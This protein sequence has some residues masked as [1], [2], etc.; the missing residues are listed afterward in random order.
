MAQ[1]GQKTITFDLIANTAQVEQSLNGIS[2]HINKIQGK[3]GTFH[4]TADVD[5]K[6][7]SKLQT[8]IKDKTIKVSVNTSDVEKLQD[9]LQA[10]SDLPDLNKAI[11]KQIKNIRKLNLDKAYSNVD[12]Q[13]ESQIVKKME[14]AQK[15]M[16]MTLKRAG[17]FESS[18]TGNQEGMMKRA[19]GFFEQIVELNG[20]LKKPFDSLNVDGTAMKLA[21]VEEQ[22]K[23]FDLPPTNVSSS[24]KEMTKEMDAQ[25]S[26]LKNLRS[27]L[28]ALHSLSLEDI[29][30]KDNFNIDKYLRELDKIDRDNYKEQL[31]KE[32]ELEESK[33][34]TGQDT[35]KDAEETKSKTKSRISTSELVKQA[36]EEA[37]IKA[38]AEQDAEQRINK[39]KDKETRDKVDTSKLAKEAE[40]EAKAKVEA[41][42]QARLKAEQEAIKKSEAETQTRLKAE[43]ETKAKAEQE[44]K[45]KAEQ[46]NITKTKSEESKSVGVDD[47]TKAVSKEP[48]KIKV[49]IDTTDLKSQ[50]SS[51]TD[52]NIKINFQVDDEINRIKSQLEGLTNQNIKINFLVDD[53]IN[54]VKSQLE[55][56]NNQNVKINIDVQPSVESIKSDLSALDKKKIDV[57]VNL[58]KSL[59]NIQKLSNAFSS[60]DVQNYMHKMTELSS[61]FRTAF[62]NL[63][64]ATK[65][66]STI[67]DDLNKKAKTLKN[68]LNSV[69]VTKFKD[70]DKIQKQIDKATKAQKKEVDK[71]ENQ[72]LKEL[73][74]KENALAKKQAQ[75]TSKGKNKGV[76]VSDGLLGDVD[77]AI[78]DAD[79]LKS[80][81]TDI[82]D[83][84]N[85]YAS[86]V[87]NLGDLRSSIADGS[88]TADQL[89]TVNE[90]LKTINELDIGD[91]RI[92]NKS[93][94]L[95]QNDFSRQF[96]EDINSIDEKEIRNALQRYYKTLGKEATKIRKSGT[97]NSAWNISYVQD[98]MNMKDTVKFQQYFTG[99]VD[100]INQYSTALRTATKA[101][102]EY[103]TS[104][105]KWMT[106]F[107]NKMSNLTQ[108]MTGADILYRAAQELREGF[109]FVKDLNSLMT[110]IDQTSDITGQGL[111]ELSQ[112]AIDQAKSLGV[113]A[114]QVTG[115]I[116]VYAAYGQ[117][118]DSLLKKAEPTT[119]LAK[120]SG[121]D[122]TTASSQ[123]LGVTKQFTELEGHED[124]IV[125]AYE[126][127]AANVQIDFAEGIQSIAEGTQVAG[128]VA[129]EA[130][131]LMPGCTVMCI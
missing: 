26:K 82:M 41:E 77:K 74:K 37:K 113:A 4:F 104:G 130:G 88:I 112:G 97:D 47:N 81:L 131:K 69:G 123:I 125:N 61:G 55:G 103:M 50:I 75:T 42:E 98:G 126:K 23:K 49:D 40:Q 46:Q 9:S 116:E 36:Q 22:F 93:G 35:S 44:A 39:T 99:S 51:I 58:G 94:I 92:S 107:R 70:M 71:A 76:K 128:S 65:A 62:A 68:T 96:V 63:R 6:N 17:G 2:S 3:D 78:K 84:Q 64:D 109:T 120:A 15:L 124:R 119:M 80:S 7:F 31:R 29:A 33:I 25:I 43:A 105:Q 24:L 48:Q 54:K 5:T 10:A 85:R 115:S 121:S 60:G 118:V 95:T 83:I 21:D 57:K 56:L 13:I 89:K 18:L 129:E 73:T 110:T 72:M 34:K 101:E 86:A 11:S 100:G 14:Q 87:K 16:N 30:N 38:Q 66:P 90:S 122:V 67:L 12:K 19:Y 91:N 108:Y 59:E 52:A 20:K 117:T 28:R 111:K 79:R 1:R 32:K 8:L 45:K 27:G 127:I 106:G 102:S 53:E 114:E